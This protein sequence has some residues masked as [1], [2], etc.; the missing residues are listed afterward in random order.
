MKQA[1]RRA[2]T[3]RALLDAA[4]RCFARSGYSGTSLDHIA[5]EAQLSR[6]G[7]YAHFPTKLALYLD[8]VAGTLARAE[9]RLTFV[10]EAL[11]QGAPPVVA[12]RRY[13]TPPDA[14]H[15][16][17]MADLWH[18]AVSEPL[19]RERLDHFRDLRLARLGEACVDAG[20][21]PGAALERAH[22][23]AAMIDALILDARLGRAVEA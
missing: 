17:L 5:A 10:A 7:I 22:A 18:T 1:E 23:T 15:V 3:H 21:A 20:D 12:A 6:G 8:V 2:R 14:A 13:I 9:D 11:R 19:V 16:A 4:T